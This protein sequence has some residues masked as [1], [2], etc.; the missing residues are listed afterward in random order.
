MFSKRIKLLHFL[1][2]FFHARIF[3]FIVLGI[4]IIFLTFFTH[5]NALEICISAV[6]SVFIGIGVNNYT[7]HE[8]RLNDEKQL[9]RQ[10]KVMLDTVALMERKI[11]SVNSHLE[12]RLT[13]QASEGIN[14]LHNMLTLLRTMIEQETLSLKTGEDALL[15][16][17]KA[18]SN[19]EIL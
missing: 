4:I 15:N 17:T 7:L 3:V 2:V 10:N 12:N 14:E 5:N 6:A 13:N 11:Y 9:R 1:H 19:K 16:K 8:T 18:D